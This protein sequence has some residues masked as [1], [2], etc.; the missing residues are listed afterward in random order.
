AGPE[1][2]VTVI[3]DADRRGR[4]RLTVE[5]NG[6]GIPRRLHRRIF[7]PGFRSVP[8]GDNHGIGLAYIRN[9]ARRIGAR[10]RLDSRPGHGS[11][12]ILTFTPGQ[13]H[14]SRKIH[15]SPRFY[16]CFIVAIMFAALFW[17]GNLYISPTGEPS[18]TKNSRTSTKPSLKTIRVLLNGGKTPTVS[19]MTSKPKPLR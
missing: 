2:N 5:D 4:L 18:S 1:A 11:R 8:T 9:T 14:R 12:F 10:L 7:R 3:C 19:A 16:S 17:T 15:L 6:T 13:K